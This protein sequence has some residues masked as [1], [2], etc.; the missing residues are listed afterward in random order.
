MRTRSIAPLLALG[1]LA[2]LVTVVPAAS[3]GCESLAAQ[4]TKCITAMYESAKKNVF[5]K[6][7]GFEGWMAAAPAAAISC[8]ELP[9]FEVDL[10]GTPALPAL[11]A[12]PGTEPAADFAAEARAHLAQF[13]QSMDEDAFAFGGATATLI[14]A[15]YGAG[16]AVLVFYSDAVDAVLLTFVPQTLPDSPDDLPGAPGEV[17]DVE[18]PELPTTPDP[19][20]GAAAVTAWLDARA[21]N[22]QGSIQASVLCVQQVPL[23]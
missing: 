2:S 15:E 5:L 10:P 1:L 3:A 19:G 14:S 16:L 23:P 4:T 9:Q 21:G 20:Q 7:G 12:V 17:P 6:L 18:A 11:P 22:A 8:S 13:Q